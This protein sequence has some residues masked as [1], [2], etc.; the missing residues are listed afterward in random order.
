MDENNDFFG[1]DDKN[2]DKF[3]VPMPEDVASEE[4]DVDVAPLP[5]APVDSIDEGA[6]AAVPDP[7]EMDVDAPT[8]ENIADVFGTDAPI[9][10]EEVPAAV[11]A[12]YDAPAE[13]A[14]TDEEAYPAE[15]DVPV[16]EEPVYEEIREEVAVEDEDVPMAAEVDYTAP[17][18]EDVLPEQFVLE[19]E[20][21]MYEQDNAPVA[22]EEEAPRAP[23][24]AVEVEEPAQPVSQEQ[25]QPIEEQPSVVAPIPSG[26]AADYNNRHMRRERDGFAGG[27]RLAEGEQVLSM[28]RLFKNGRVYMTNRRLLVE[29]SLHTDLPIAS[30]AGFS[31]GKFARTKVFKLLMGIFFMLA[32]AAIIV[33]FTLPNL[34]GNWSVFED[35]GWLQYVLYGVGGVLGVIGLAMVCTSVYRRFLLTV[36]TEGVQQTVSVRSS[37]GKGDVDLYQS[38]AYGAAG[39]D[40]KMFAANA[41]AR[42]LDI[43]R[44]YCA[45]KRRQ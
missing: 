23:Q 30:V 22:A 10:E 38:I 29:S 26:L 45:K 13:Q 20:E 35:M 4:V 16:A 40:Y 39:P 41:G 28:Y 21:P 6:D 15:D 7:E 34:L 27:F 12:V 18:E 1:K 17:Q 9:Q 43:K 2:F 5:S 44:V 37:V 25:Q 14:P 8:V 3:D 11:E 31:V 19:E 42:L 33:V 32:C 36:F 24:P